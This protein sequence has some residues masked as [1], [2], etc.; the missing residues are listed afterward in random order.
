MKDWIKDDALTQNV[1]ETYLKKFNKSDLPYTLIAGYLT[2]YTNWGKRDSGI[3]H[4]DQSEKK[5]SEDFK[6]AAEDQFRKLLKKPDGTLTNN[7]KNNIRKDMNAKKQSRF[8]KTKYTSPDG[9]FKNPIVDNL[10]KRSL[11]GS[12]INDTVDHHTVDYNRT[13]K[14]HTTR[15]L[16]DFELPINYD[17]LTTEKQSTTPNSKY[18]DSVSATTVRKEP[19]NDT[20]QLCHNPISIANDSDSMKLKYLRL[21]KRI[22]HQVDSDSMTHFSAA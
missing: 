1:A 8:K 16:S 13:P 22:I 19:I 7:E 12:E 20:F 21:L 3:V 14:N 15:S 4:S 18:F 2:I 6:N 17:H 11:F 5:K 10:F 9:P